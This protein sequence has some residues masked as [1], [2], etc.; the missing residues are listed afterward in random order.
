MKR[1]DSQ[2]RHFGFVKHNAH[3]TSNNILFCYSVPATGLRSAM[4]QHIFM[5]TLYSTYGPNSMVLNNGDL[6]ILSINTYGEKRIALYLLE[7]LVVSEL[8]LI[9]CYNQKLKI[10]ANLKILQNVKKL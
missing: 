1:S 4:S 2:L 10:S 9:W 3:R 5:C 8:L 7:S 6:D